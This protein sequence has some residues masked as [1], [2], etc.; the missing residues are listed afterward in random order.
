MY[1]KK[2]TSWR[3]VK[4]FLLVLPGVLFVILFHYVPLWGWVYG[5]YQY[6]P[7]R[8]LADCQFVGF[9]NITDLFGNAVIKLT[10]GI[11]EF[12]DVGSKFEGVFA[13]FSQQ[14]TD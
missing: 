7:G 4:P 1:Q 12:I 2:K 11:V 14:Q 3:N 8:A 10:T 13:L 5:F 9:K 6:K